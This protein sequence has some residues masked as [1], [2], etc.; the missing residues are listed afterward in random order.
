M[1]HNVIALLQELRA[2]ALE[3]GIAA[4]IFTMKKK[5]T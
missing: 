5:A 4:A 3:K 2:Y 1:Q